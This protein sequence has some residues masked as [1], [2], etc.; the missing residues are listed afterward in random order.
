MIPLILTLV[1]AALMAGADKILERQAH[2]PWQ[3][4]KVLVGAAALVLLAQV[5]DPGTFAIVV[6][7]VKA[8]LNQLAD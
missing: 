1:R 8:L 3:K 2:T 6:D 4:L 5:F 7:Y